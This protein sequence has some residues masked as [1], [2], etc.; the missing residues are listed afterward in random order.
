LK[1]LFQYGW[2]VIVKFFINII[3]GICSTPIRGEEKLLTAPFF[4]SRW[5]Y[6]GFTFENGSGDICF[7]EVDAIGLIKLIP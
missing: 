1:K 7:V 6:K 3:L 5:T 2:Y 4:S